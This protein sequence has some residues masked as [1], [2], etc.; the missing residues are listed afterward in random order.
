MNFGTSIP[1]ARA[2]SRCFPVVAAIV[3][4]LV[5]T[6]PAQQQARPGPGGG[7]PAAP[8]KDYDQRA[9]EIYEFRKAVKGGPSR[10]RKSTFTNAGCVTTSWRRVARPSSSACS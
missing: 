10:A 5:S 9:L 3:A 7:E 2:I 4:G 1:I 8:A 6:A